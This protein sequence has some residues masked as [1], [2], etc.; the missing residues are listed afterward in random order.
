MK[1]SD[2]EATA[3][4]VQESNQ[5]EDKIQVEI[6]KLQSMQSEVSAQV[7]KIAFSLL[8]KR[9][10]ILVGDHWWWWRLLF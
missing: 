6:L 5:P 7:A 4:R 3:I 10:L 8:L 2:E 9:L 1:I